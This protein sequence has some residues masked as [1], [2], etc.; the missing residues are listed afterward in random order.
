MPVPCSRRSIIESSCPP[1]ARP[2]DVFRPID[3][4]GNNVAHPSWG[5][6]GADLL[7]LSP[8]AYTNGYNS[9]S[10]AQDPSAR[11]ISDIVNNQANPADPSQDI[12]TVNQRSLSA[13]ADAFGQFMDHD[14]DLTLDNGA[15]MPISV[16]V[17]DPIGGPDDTPLAFAASKHR[18]GDRHRARAIPPSRSTASRRTS[19]CRRFTAPT[20]RRTTPCGPSLAV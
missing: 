20:R 16:P 12:A 19:T 3:E 13:L 2:A 7:R 15:S 11:L 4:V 6:A 10:L 14:M 8:A 5:V 17:G 1:I 9:P 18:S